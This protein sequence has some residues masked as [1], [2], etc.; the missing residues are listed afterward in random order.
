LA[1][2]P[3][4]THRLGALLEGRRALVGAAARER[5]LAAAAAVVEQAAASHGRRDDRASAAVGAPPVDEPAALAAYARELA[6]A[7]DAAVERYGLT[8]AANRAT[9][10]RCFRALEKDAARYRAFLEARDG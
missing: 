8:S 7:P 10:A 2:L 3:A 5:L 4:L 1:A 6:A 9:I